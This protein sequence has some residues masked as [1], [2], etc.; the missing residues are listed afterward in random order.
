MRLKNHLVPIILLFLCTQA[1]AYAFSDY[2]SRIGKKTLS[3]QHLCMYGTVYPYA[4][5]MVY[6]HVQDDIVWQKGVLELR[7]HD[8]TDL[9]V[10]IVG[11]ICYAALCGLRDDQLQE[12]LVLTIYGALLLACLEQLVCICQLHTY[13]SDQT[14][15]Q[16]RLYGSNYVKALLACACAALY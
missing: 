7:T 6:Q 14:K 10:S 13:A 16:Y 1:H 9:C 12:H 8:I 4:L 3:L 5:N 15:Q 11:E 2:V